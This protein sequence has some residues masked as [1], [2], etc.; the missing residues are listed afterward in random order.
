MGSPRRQWQTVERDAAAVRA[1]ADALSIPGSL[2]GILC[3]RALQDP[4]QARAFLNPRLSEM[5]DPLLMTGMQVAADRVLRALTGKQ[6]IVVYGD[7]DVDGV[8]GTA[9][10]LSVLRHLGA[11]VE[12]FTPERFHDGYGLTRDPVERC[13]AKHNPELII[14]VDCGTLSV[15]PVQFINSKGVDVVVTDHH[16]L[17]GP[18]A[19]ALAV[20]NPKQDDMPAIH[21]LA[22]VAVAFKLCHGVVKMALDRGLELPEIDLRDWLDLVALGVVADVVPLRGEN[23][24]L[25]HSGLD[26]LNRTARCGLHALLEVAGVRRPVRSGQVAFMLAPRLN[27]AGRMGDAGNALQLLLSKVPEEAKGLAQRLNAANTERRSIESRLFTAAQKQVDEEYPDDEP[28]GVVTGGG[29]WHVGVVGIVASRLCELYRC[30][31]VVIGFDA[32]GQGRGSAR[33]ALGVDVLEVLTACDDLLE[34]YGGHRAAAGLRIHAGQFD[35]FRRRFNER[36]AEAIGGGDRRPVIKVDTWLDLADA[37]ETLLEALDH[38][39][40][41]G[42]GNPEPVLGFRHVRLLGPPRIVGGDHLK[43]T[44]TLGERRL[45]AIAF[46]MGSVEVPDGP[47]DVLGTLQENVYRGRRSLQLRVADFRPAVSQ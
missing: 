1:L 37:D 26:R 39:A 34:G 19:P 30:P 7:Y 21:E 16:E 10:V 41:F 25:T 23:R 22:G 20:V 6:K 15:E 13:L 29:D 40:P 38:M 33:S 28:F 31:S 32:E 5:S 9:V 11:S 14:T 18:V 47:L 17:S 45:E 3:G 35:A 42:K 4:D 36:C 43:M 27:A 44:L 8:T 46:R 12:S 2:A 24:I